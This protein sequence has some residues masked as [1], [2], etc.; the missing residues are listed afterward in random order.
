MDKSKH[1][2]ANDILDIIE[3][4]NLSDLD[5]LSDEEDSEVIEGHR[6]ELMLFDDLPED[7]CPEIDVFDSPTVPVSNQETLLPTCSLSKASRPIP[8]TSNVSRHVSIEPRPIDLGLSSTPQPTRKTRLSKSPAQQPLVEPSTF[9]RYLEGIQL[10]ESENISW[11]RQ[12]FET[13]NFGNITVSNNETVP[14]VNDPWSYFCRYITSDIIELFAEK[15]NLYATQ[16]GANNFGLTVNETKIFLGL[17]LTVGNLNFPRL[18]MYWENNY[19]LAMFE[20]MSRNRFCSILTNLHLVDNLEI[21]VNNKDRF[22]KSRPLYDAIRKRCQELPIEENV[23]IDEQMIPFTGKL[24]VK[25]YI[26]GK[27]TPYGIKNYCLCGKSGILYDFLLY[28]GSNTE[29]D[30][31]L[32]DALG[33]LPTVVLQFAMNN[34]LFEPHALFF[35][36]YFSSYKLFEA[37]RQ[38]NIKAAGTVRLNRFGTK[39]VKK[40][41]DTRPPLQSEAELKAK[42][43]GACDEIRDA[44]NNVTLVSWFDNSLVTVASNFIASGIPKEVRRWNRKTKEYVNVEMPEVIHWYNSNMGGVDKLDQMISYYR[45]FIKSK[46]WTLRMICHGLDLAIVNSWLE[47]RMDAEKNSL[48]RKHTMDLLK[49]RTSLVNHLLFVGQEAVDRRKRGRPAQ[50]EELAQ[51]AP[52]KRGLKQIRPPKEVVLDKVDHL[53]QVDVKTESTRCKKPGCTGKTHFF[54]LKCSIHLCLTAKRN[55]FLDFHTK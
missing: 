50:Q 54:C 33:Q 35:D 12:P 45:T 27:P 52:K 13:N 3:S 30:G 40:S 37:L 41:I 51:P 21:P 55:C 24:N 23:S 46:K 47:Y 31:V 36:N 2:L 42:G 26:K 48:P 9:S 32:L 16:K 25:Q 18:R 34:L 44:A 49:F 11:V 22:I 53:P 28:Q 8:S 17:L 19:K 10:T 15:T 1:L 4:G 29:F 20:K 43:R 7:N 14:N 5:C 38:L 39:N 6:N